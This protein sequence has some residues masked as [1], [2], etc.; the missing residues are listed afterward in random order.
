[1]ILLW[2]VI[3]AV[4]QKKQ[5]QQQQT[6]GRPAP[7]GARRQA[8][9]AADAAEQRRRELAARQQAGGAQ[10]TAPGGPAA[11]RA[12][13]LAARR[14][15]QLEEL[16][17][18]RSGRQ[19]SPQVRARAVV[20]GGGLPAPTPVR[21]SPPT[22]LAAQPKV[23][24]S[25]PPEPPRVPAP[26]TMQPSAGAA[27]RPTTEL[28]RRPR[29]RAR[30]CRS[31]AASRPPGPRTAGA[32]SRR[33]PR[34]RRR[35]P[36]AA[37][38]RSVDPTALPATP[39]PQAR[40]AERCRADQAV[41]TGDPH[42]LRQLVVLPRDPRRRRWPCDLRRSDAHDPVAGADVAHLD[43]LGPGVVARGFASGSPKMAARSPRGAQIGI[44]AAHDGHAIAE[45]SA[46]RDVT[47]ARPWDRA[48]TGVLA[49]QW[50]RAASTACSWGMPD[51]RHPVPDGV[52]RR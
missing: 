15:A 35:R 5:Q 33:R 38:L 46:G 23:I 10:T 29:R 47:S 40:P 49:R 19:S 21:P 14:R 18:R 13:D 3:A 22:V 7:S 34:P 36:S 11:A 26:P 39:R 32:A 4:A 41:S 6:G 52:H 20:P 51:Q 16:R 27:G 43:R 31:R 42:T 24:R 44:L 8:P 45:G 12:D 48:S 2:Q 28:R 25:I 9:G 30:S 37:P 50:R 17:R 1:M